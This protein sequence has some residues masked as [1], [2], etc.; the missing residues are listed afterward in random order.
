MKRSEYGECN[1]FVH[2]EKS[3]VSLTFIIK[4]MFNVNK[5]QILMLYC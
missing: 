5:A 4:D 3:L 1:T 2:P